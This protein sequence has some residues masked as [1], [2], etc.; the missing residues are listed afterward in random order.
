MGQASS[1]GLGLAIALA[2][3]GV[4]AINGDGSTLMNLGS[5]VTIPAHP[6]NLT[7]VVMDNGLYEVTGG[8]PTAGGGTVDFCELARGAGFGRV[9]GFSAAEEWRDGVGEVL[10]EPG[11]AFVCLRVEARYGQKTP[12]PPHPMAEQIERL[13]NELDV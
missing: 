2:P 3:R 4:I 8:Q 10:A 5:L 13:R 6:A 7:L 9:Y 11:P 12:R 1:L